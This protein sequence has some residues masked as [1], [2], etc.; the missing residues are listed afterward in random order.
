M[1]LAWTE[2]YLVVAVL[3]RRFGMRMKLHDV[4]FER[5]IKITADGF[6]A[7]P[8]TDSRGLRVLIN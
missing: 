6:N 2:L 8:S 4:V 3:V 5:D 7:L 1:N